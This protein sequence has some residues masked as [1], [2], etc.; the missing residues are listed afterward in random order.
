MASPTK[1]RLDT[2][3][4]VSRRD[5]ESVG[6]LLRRFNQRVRG[7]GLLQAAR[8]HQ[9]RQ[10]EPN[11][12]TRRKSALVRATDRKRYQQLRKLGKSVKK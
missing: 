9:V 4:E 3:L 12:I 1:T 11:R 10:E 5:K 6:S 2:G 8:R 7:S